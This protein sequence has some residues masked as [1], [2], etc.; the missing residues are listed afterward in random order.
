MTRKARRKRLQQRAL[1]GA[2][3][4]STAFAARPAHGRELAELL[5]H[6]EALQSAAGDAAAQRFDIPPGQLAAVL[7]ALQRQT[8]ETIAL[9]DP[10]AGLIFSPGVTGVFTLERAL[11]QA[12]TGTSLSFTRT[13]VRTLAVEFRVNTEAVSVTG[14][15]PAMIGS[16]KFTEPL[17]DIPQSI[18]VVPSEVMAEQGATTLRDALR[19]VAGISLAAGEGGAQGD[20]L[21]IRGFTRAQR[22]LHR[23]HARLRQLLPRPVQP[24]TGA[25]AQGAL[26]CGVRPRHHRRRPQPGDQGAC[27]RVVRQRRGQFRHRRHQAGDAGH[28]RAGDRARRRRR[29]PHERDG[30]R[31]R[32]GRPRYREQP[33][34]W[35]CAVARARP[36][37]ADPRDVH[38]LP[39]GRER[40][41]G[42]RHP[43]A[44]Q[45]AGAGRAEL[46]LRVC[47]HEFPGYARRHRGREGRASVRLERDGHQPAP[48]RQ[49]RPRCPDH[50]GEDPGERDAEHAARRDPGRSESDHRRQHRD[51]P[52]E[53]VRRDQPV[54]DRR[55][56]S[57]PGHAASSSPAKP[58]IR[59]ARRLPACR[60]PAC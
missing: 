41:P 39:P 13:G 29:V 10:A 32:R 6:S 30:H 35:G 45:R 25:G 12:L 33:A 20:N 50:R 3:V 1:V 51:V 28:Q 16:P 56:A 49:L 4:A 15:A 55:R 52:A 21:T 18:D 7:A 23:R 24:G 54:L 42:L 53:P 8:G 43:V 11:E 36:R 26:I 19:N 58:R 14:R 60:T 27:P 9:P 59:R 57:H 2:F 34:L 17:R 22:H 38:L 46:V 48:L 47:R 44:V 37:H 5:R 40:H 31:C